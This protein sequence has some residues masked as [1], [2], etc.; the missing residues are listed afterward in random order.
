M[1]GSLWG[2]LFY[3]YYFQE[4]LVKPEIPLPLRE[5]RQVKPSF[6]TLTQWKTVLKTVFWLFEEHLGSG[7]NGGSL[8][9]DPYRQLNNRSGFYTAIPAWSWTL[10]PW[11]EHLCR[12]ATTAWN[13]PV[14]FVDTDKKVKNWA[15]YKLPRRLSFLWVGDKQQHSQHQSCR[16]TFCSLELDH[17]RGWKHRNWNGC[18]SQPCF[19]VG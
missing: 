16:P 10:T 3:Y 9:R 12:Y 7:F 6:I 1:A 8:C 19:F 4:G 5:H 18:N 13:L 11:P 2:F 15:K 17:L 14:K